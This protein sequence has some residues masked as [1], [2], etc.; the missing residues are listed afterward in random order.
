MFLSTVFLLS[1]LGHQGT[2]S[3]FIFEEPTPGYLA[4]SS[5]TGEVPIESRYIDAFPSVTKAVR[6]S[7][8]SAGITGAAIV[9]MEGE[10]IKYSRGFGYANLATWEPFGSVTA[11]RCG[12]ISKTATALAV[13][14]LVS[15]GK[16]KLDDNVLKILK[17]R[18]EIAA[19]G[20]IKPGW[21]QIRVRDLL[22]HASGIKNTS[23]Y[24]TSHQMASE[25]GKSMRLSRI[26]LFNYVLK[27]QALDGVREKFSYSNLNFELLSLII[28]LKTGLTYRDALQELV[29]KPLGIPASEMFLSPTRT[30]PPDQKT[31]R[32]DV[33]PKEARCYQQSSK[34]FESIFVPGKMVAEAYGGLDGDILSG[35]GHISFSAEAIA[36]MV[37]TLRTRPTSYLSKGVWDEMLKPPGYVSKPGNGAVSPNYFYSKGT[38]VKRVSRY[39]YLFSHSAM[40]MHAGGNYAYYKENIHYVVIANCNMKDGVPTVDS[41]LSKAV[42]QG[43]IDAGK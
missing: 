23:I 20:P 15:D 5:W 19:F 28:E 1:S 33:L 38:F 13:L 4:K 31:F 27:N 37:S 10:E 32:N 24:L 25:M 42:V 12:S 41:I 26:D 35:A 11:S 29:V 18:A 3:G 30:V 39:K 8:K 7:M 2:N 21:E 6:G 22:D 40:L 34:L 9:I 36:K 43:L 16:L 14:K 17:T